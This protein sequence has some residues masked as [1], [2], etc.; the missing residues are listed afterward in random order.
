MYWL[1]NPPSAVIFSIGPVNFYWYGLIMVLAMVIG[2][3]LTWS[4]AKKHNWKSS[5]LLDLAFN[6]IISGVIGARLYHVIIHWPDYSHNLIDIV[7]IWEGGLAIHGAIIGG[8]LALL[9]TCHKRH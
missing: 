3:Y 1:N 5:D 7:K 4:L 9:L 8:G 2:Y 6:V